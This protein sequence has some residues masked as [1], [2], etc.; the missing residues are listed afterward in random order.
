MKE[1]VLKVRIDQLSQ[2]PYHQQVY[3][4]NPNDTLKV[5]FL[6]TGKK[7]VYPI[8]VVPNTEFQY[9]YWVISGMNRL[10]TLIQMEQ[11]HVEVI[12]YEIPDGTELKNLIVDLNKQRI[13]SG[14]E[15]LREFRHFLEMYPDQR[16]IPGCRYSKIGKE[17]GRSKDRVK[18]YVML[19]KF[20]EGEGDV[21]LESLF[22]GELNL[23][24]VSHLQKVVEKYPEKFNSEKSFEKT[25]DRRFDYG[26]L[27]YGIKIL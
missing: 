15:L 1:K 9:L 23:S 4:V 20:F 21:I 5:S 16:G 19:N 7:P 3:E 2:H 10:E 24:Q 13:K 11:T 25:C 22:G 8:V 6:R 12:V 17:I 18:D 14:R 26:R 27:D